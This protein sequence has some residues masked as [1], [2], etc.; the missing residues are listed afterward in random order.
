MKRAKNKTEVFL[1][2]LPSRRYNSAMPKSDG[3]KTDKEK[4]DGLKA[5]AEAEA[6][7]AIEGIFLTEEEKALVLKMEE[8]GLSE[9][10]CI[11][12]VK[13]YMRDNPI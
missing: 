2:N 5:I 9:E 8:E 3:Q 4:Q 1:Y 10:E 12:R 6:N 11:A 13:A 7:L